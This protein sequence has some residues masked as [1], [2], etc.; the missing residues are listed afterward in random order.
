MPPHERITL[1]SNVAE[2]WNGSSWNLFQNLI[3]HTQLQT[4]HHLTITD[5]SD[6]QNCKL[7]DGDIL[8]QNVVR[9]FFS[10]ILLVIEV[11]SFGLIP[12]HWL[13]IWCFWKFLHRCLP[14]LDVMIE[15]FL[16]VLCALYTCCK[17]RTVF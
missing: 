17:L 12:F 11:K 5:L 3:Q 6:S 14:N 2:G 13:R 9:N 1:T 10:I 4:F 16:F 7:E 15:V 8:N